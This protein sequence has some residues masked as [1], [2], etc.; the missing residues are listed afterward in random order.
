MI[1]RRAM[2]GASAGALLLPGAARAAMR[3]RVAPYRTP[4]KYP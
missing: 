4:Y 1:D 2:L 3:D